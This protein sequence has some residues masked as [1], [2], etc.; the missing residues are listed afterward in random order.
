MDPEPVLVA[1]V[2]EWL[3]RLVSGFVL[4]LTLLNQVLTCSLGLMMLSVRMSR[5][6]SCWLV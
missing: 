1:A 4:L 3:D 5:S 2:E 6:L